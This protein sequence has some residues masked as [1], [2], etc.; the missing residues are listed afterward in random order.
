ME[1]PKKYTIKLCGY[2]LNST[3]RSCNFCTTAHINKSKKVENKNIYVYKFE[4]Y[5]F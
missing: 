5:G 1:K 3:T 4:M 2:I